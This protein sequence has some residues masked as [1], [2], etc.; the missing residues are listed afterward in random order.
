MIGDLIFLALTAV[1][2]AE[3]LGSIFTAEL[4]RI[5]AQLVDEARD[6]C[7]FGGRFRQIG[8]RVVGMG[9][10]G[11]FHA[12]L[13]EAGQHG[14]VGKRGNVRCGHGRVGAA[15]DGLGLF[16]EQ[17]GLNVPIELAQALGTV[18]DHHVQA[19]TFAAVER[20]RVTGLLDSAHQVRDG[21]LPQGKDVVDGV[22]VGQHEVTGGHAGQNR[23]A[24]GKPAVGRSGEQHVDVF[25]RLRAVA[26]PA[27][28]GAGE[29]AKVVGG[30]FERLL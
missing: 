20:G 7:V 6:C 24:R 25:A 14:V 26:V 22:G 5:G 18:I 29:R 15:R 11:G 1:E 28:I 16:F 13:I 23:R 4:V 27:E 2:R 19:V 8:V 12:P 10:V 17:V 3:Q 9:G 30:T 21:D